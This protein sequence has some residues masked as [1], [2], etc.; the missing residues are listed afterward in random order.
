[1]T[2]VLFF[3][4]CVLS[5]NLVASQVIYESLES[6]KLGESRDIKIQLPRGYDPE[7]DVL[8]PLII[9]MDGDYL[10]E[11][12]VGNIDY[13]SYWGDMPKSIV[14][15]INQR[16]T[17]NEDLS[18]SAETYF[19]SDEGSRFFEF[20]GMELIPYIN[21]KYL[22]SEFRIIIGHDLSANFLNFYLF[23]EEPLFRGYIAFSPELSPEMET[24][25]SE[26]LKT[27]T[28]DTFYYLATG[29]NDV[30]ELK[31]KILQL[32]NSLKS[33]EN[34]KLHYRFDNFEDADHYSLVG[35]GIPKAINEIFGLF[36]PI[37]RKE[38]DE[39][40]LTY[41]GSPYEYLM[42]K[43]E[44]IEFFYGFEKKVVENDIRAVAA[45]A[46]K[47][48]DLDAMKDLSKLASREYSKSMISAYYTGL[49][50]EM[51]G[52]TKKALQ[53]YQSGLL[54]TESQFITKDMLLDKIYELQDK[55]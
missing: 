12:V 16:E 47:K 36:K 14:V 29:T 46:R 22:T 21:S 37:N 15:G 8:Y 20:I 55:K 54:L 10:F 28:E 39:K 30:N 11:P 33:V 13:H 31:Q 7:S 38:Y 45:A 34:P 4:V 44:D 1:M 24:R 52:N 32:D 41:E 19:P 3:F 42:K 49:Y 2:K 53:N 27:Q 17:R 26:R 48:G 18:Y 25:L 23:K 35:L 5:F 9:V 40:M 51:D 6:S 50:Y 43:Y